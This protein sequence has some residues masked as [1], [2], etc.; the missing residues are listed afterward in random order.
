MD[1][2]AWWKAHEKELPLMAHVARK[3]LGIQATSTDCERTFS[4]SGRTVCALRTRL[5]P[6][7]VRKLVLGSTNKDLVER[8]VRELAFN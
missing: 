8:L 7:T 4:L 1:L 2:F 6:A 3:V 5:H